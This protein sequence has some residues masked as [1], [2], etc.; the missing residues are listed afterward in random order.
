M[1]LTI[2]IPSIGRPTLKRTLDSIRDQEL[3]DGDRVVVALDTFE[4]PPRPDVA[5]LVDSYGAPFSILPFDGG[6]HWRGMHQ[7][8]RAIEVAETD[9]LCGLGDDDCYTV[10]AIAKLRQNLRPEW[11]CLFQFVHPPPSRHVLWD[12]PVLQACHISGCCMAAP[13]KGMQPAPLDHV[14]ISD[15][16]WIERNVVNKTMLWIPDVYVVARPDEWTEARWPT[17]GVKS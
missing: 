16:W 6:D 10:G 17:A 13:V 8:N 11:V 3:L 2:V 12:K 15:F 1:T 9:F 5:E 4:Q 7:L 14:D